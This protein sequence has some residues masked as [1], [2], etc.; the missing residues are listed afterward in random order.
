MAQ[1]NKNPLSSSP[2]PYKMPIKT[3]IAYVQRRTRVCYN[4]T[5]TRFVSNIA[6]PEKPVQEPRNELA[7]SEHAANEQ[8]DGLNDIIRSL[9]AEL[10]TQETSSKEQVANPEETVLQVRHQHPDSQHTPS[11]MEDSVNETI[12]SLRTVLRA[13]DGYSNSEI[14]RHK[15]INQELLIQLGEYQQNVDPLTRIIHA[16]EQKHHCEALYAQGRV[17]NAAES[18]I[19]IANIVNEDERA[20]KD[21]FILDWLADFTHQC[22]ATL[23]KV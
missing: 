22:V 12:D 1:T 16:H 7:K 15:Q 18:L 17:Y 9:R 20:N 3:R 8:K 14:T 13:R 4:A 2:N 23:E 21:K 11:R 5:L 19:E 10:H 6:D